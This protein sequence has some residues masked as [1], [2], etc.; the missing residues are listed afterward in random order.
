MDQRSFNVFDLGRVTVTYTECEHTATDNGIVIYD[1]PKISIHLTDGLY[2]VMNDRLVGGK[3]GDVSLYAPNEVHFG[4]FAFE[5]HFRFLNIFLSKDFLRRVETE[6]PPFSKLFASVAED[7]TNCIRGNFEE[8][9]KILEA[10]E[11]LAV[12]SKRDDVHDEMQAFSLIL[13]LL[14]LF[15][16]LYSNP[17]QVSCVPL[18][19]PIVQRTVEYL[20]KHYYEK[21]TVSELAQRVG[22]STVY[23]SKIFKMYMG[24]SVYQY[25]TEYRVNRAAAL[26]N[27][28]ALVTEACYRSGFSDCSSFIRTFNRIMKVTPHQYKQRNREI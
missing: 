26:L 11:K 25:L 13:N 12:F 17:Q 21:I 9:T 3:R 23:L 22:C 28:G 10:A 15:T 19:T 14:L 24:R 1:D 6:Y 2:G 4:R 7:R 16:E 20:T 8:K 27:T 18:G 5:G